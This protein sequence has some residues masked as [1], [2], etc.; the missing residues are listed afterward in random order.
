M[1]TLMQFGGGGLA[2]RQYIFDPARQVSL[3]DNFKDMVTSTVRMPGMRGGFSNYGSAALPSAIGTVSYTFWLYFNG[4]ADATAQRQAVAA[5]AGWGWQRLYKQPED[6]TQR[7]RWCWAYVNNEPINFNAR[8]R[9]FDRQQVTITF[10]VPDPH[11]YSHPFNVSQMD[12]GLVMDAGLT[13]AG[14]PG[15]V[16][17]GPTT[18]ELNVG[19]DAA[20]LPILRLEAA[21]SV[22]AYFDDPG[23]F[24]DDPGLV[25]NGIIGGE[26]EDFSLRRV[27]RDTLVVTHEMAWAGMLTDSDRLVIDCGAESVIY[28]DS[29]V[30]NVSGWDDFTRTRASILELE[31]GV[32]RLDVGGTFTDSVLLTVEYVEAWR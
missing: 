17:T 15:T 3:S 1:D 11:W 10:H 19:G 20:T 8:E 21:V 13:L 24:F 29:D 23:L 32:N 28:E 9:N 16:L 7:P 31:P 18:I 26:V 25:F 27:D 30:G 5:M 6:P 14:W 12:D 22:L 2:G 4:S